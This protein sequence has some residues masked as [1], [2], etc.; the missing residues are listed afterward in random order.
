MGSL[1]ALGCE[2]LYG[3]SYS[4]TKQATA[5]ATVLSLLGWGFFLLYWRFDYCFHPDRSDC[6]KGSRFRFS[7]FRRG[8]YYRRGIY[9]EFQNECTGAVTRKAAG[10]I[11]YS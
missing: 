5:G 8:S 9:R 1:C 10:R 6:L 11:L 2:T 7:A 3:L 4:F